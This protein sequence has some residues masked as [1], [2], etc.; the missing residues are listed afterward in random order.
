MPTHVE[1]GPRA[2]GILIPSSE[3]PCP[4]CQARPGDGWLKHTDEYGVQRYRCPEC[5]ANF[6]R[7]PNLPPR[8]AYKDT[9]AMGLVCEEC[10]Y[11]DR[12]AG[13]GNGKH[14]CII[15]EI[16]T[17]GHYACSVFERPT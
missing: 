13:E 7:E 6:C 14:R 4:K 5:E 17:E 8:R 12:E 1:I 10:R 3:T 9:R 16:D 2:R 11:W 15:F